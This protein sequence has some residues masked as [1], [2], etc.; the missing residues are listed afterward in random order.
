MKRDRA[1]ETERLNGGRDAPPHD[2]IS[3]SAAFGIGTLAG[4]KVFHSKEQCH[5]P[6][7]SIGN[8]SH[9]IDAISN[10]FW[11]PLQD[12]D[13][14]AEGEVWQGER[15]EREREREKERERKYQLSGHVF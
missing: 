5:A 4:S 7:K 3:K 9:P 8:T 11:A 1:I 14:E 13:G 15:R 12:G 6:S 2:F 10:P